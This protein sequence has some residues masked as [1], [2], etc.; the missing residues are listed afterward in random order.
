MRVAR[1]RGRYARVQLRGMSTSRVYISLLFGTISAGCTAAPASVSQFGGIREVM[2]D[3]QVESR[4]ALAEVTRKPHA[5]AIGA[6]QGLAG[7]V[8]ILDGQVWVARAS[9][10]NLKVS[11]PDPVA[12]DSATL[13]TV[14]HV[15]KWIPIRLQGATAG[16][17]LAATIERSARAAGIDVD[18]PFPFQVEG[19]LTA[20]DLHVV[21]GACPSGA[22]EE[23]SP[24]R[25]SLNEPVEAT[26]A[27]FFA[28][29]EEGTM[30]HHGTSLHMH[31]LLRRGGEMLTGHVDR[32]SLAPGALLSLPEDHR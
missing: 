20:L 9:G 27:G 17:D 18:R 16:V 14:A 25:R 11:G 7:E 12:S 24:W 22:T 21:R 1:G 13:L 26:L 8:T 28:K 19:E 32:V 15:P 29:H 4:I 30:T 31:A 5:H 3:G 10:E 23:N 2:R 6:L